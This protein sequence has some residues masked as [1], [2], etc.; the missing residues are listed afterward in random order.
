MKILYVPLDERPCNYDYP[1]YI[2]RL[3]PQ[4]QLVIPPLSLLGK[5]K[6]AA[7]VDCLWDWLMGS[8]PDCDCAIVSLEML[9][10]GG[11][12]PS[13][14]HHL[15][16]AELLKRLQQFR[17]IASNWPNVHF[18]A[19]N[20]IM[21]A[22]RYSSSEEE[23]DYYETYGEQL[24][25]WGWLQ[26][27]ARTVRLSNIALPTADLVTAELLTTSLPVLEQTQMEALSAT[28]P[29]QH[30][31]DY[32]ERRRKNLEVNLAAIDLV[33]DGVLEFLAIPQDDCAEFGFTA[34]DR[35]RVYD[36]IK[37]R[38][39]HDLIHV[40][41]GADEVGCTLLA[42]AYTQQLK[43][44]IKIY[45]LYSSE[46][47]SRVIPLY[48]D[49]P[50]ADS[51]ELHIRVAGAEIASS[52]SDA[53]IV[54][55]VNVPKRHSQEAK[56]QPD[57]TNFLQSPSEFVDRIQRLVEEG[58]PVAVADVAFANGGDTALIQKVDTVCGWE[59]VLAYSGWNTCCN[60]LGSTIAAAIVGKQSNVQEAIAFNTIYH[61]LE[62]WGYQT[63]IRWALMDSWI[64]NLGA[65]YF[66]LNGHSEVVE[67]EIGRRLEAIWASI[68]QHSF[69]NWELAS[70]DIRSPWKR[71]FEIGIALKIQRRAT[72]QEVHTSQ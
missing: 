28:I 9:V 56:D 19:S 11:L 62:D 47:G 1:Q 36:R 66:D 4:L 15:S 18:L 38:G 8:L 58:T 44:T 49:R 60:S 25:Q 21:R 33:T 46:Q 5:K 59:T 55:A 14:L 42:R 16:R 65:T 61:L 53:D 68:L 70:L 57:G 43:Q 51:T 3:K 34:S 2:A 72:E 64:E 71:M 26:D 63:I 10:Y 52:F 20:L 22:P 31:N 37:T 40:Y 41:P 32:Q 50:I 39:L 69:Q 29:P 27:R 13:R 30:L 24:F 45:P 35:R 23:P 6:Q 17:T 12:L 54:L 7:D 67:A 48:E